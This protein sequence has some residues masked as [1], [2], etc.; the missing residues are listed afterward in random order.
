MKLS[1]IDNKE[2]IVLLASILFVVLVFASS[3]YLYFNPP[4]KVLEAKV[5]DVYQSNGNTFIL[6][7][8]AGKLKLDGLYDIEIGATYR[9]T[10]QS[11]HRNLATNVISIDK[12]S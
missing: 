2:R 4:V 8:G 11:T 6:T 12:I 1:E 9:I 3:L 10:Y 7:Y 5:F